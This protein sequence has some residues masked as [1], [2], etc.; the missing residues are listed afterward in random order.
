MDRLLK[1]R[2]GTRPFCALLW[3]DLGNRL[4]A[5]EELAPHAREKEKGEWELLDSGVDMLVGMIDDPAG[6]RALLGKD[7]LVYAGRDIAGRAF[8]TPACNVLL[9]GLFSLHADAIQRGALPA[10]L[11]SYKRSPIDRTATE[12][13]GCEATCPRLL[14]V[15]TI[16]A[17]DAAGPDAA[18]DAYGTRAAYFGWEVD[19]GPAL[20]RAIKAEP[21][22]EGRGK[23]LYLQ[24]GWLDGVGV[25]RGGTAEAKLAVWETEDRVQAFDHLPIRAVY[26]VEC[27]GGPP[28]RVWVCAVKLDHRHPTPAA[29]EALLYGSPAASAEDADVVA[30]SFTDLEVT[31]G[32]VGGLR[33]LLQVGVGVDWCVF[34]FVGVYVV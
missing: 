33:R 11:P 10:P 13:L 31:E 19:G 17:R 30:L 28:L 4:V 20:Q 8:T 12:L 3:G 18:G 26:N 15:P 25:Y 6:R 1:A 14:S 21:A 9:R 16:L 32:N 34:V 22:A 27:P 7:A 2:Q 5:F 24:L 23:N 29:L